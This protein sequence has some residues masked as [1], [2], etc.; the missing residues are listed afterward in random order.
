MASE[1]KKHRIY[2][3]IYSL[4]KLWS[5]QNILRCWAQSKWMLLKGRFLSRT[6]WVLLDPVENLPLHAMLEFSPPQHQM[7]DFEDGVFRIF[8]FGEVLDDAVF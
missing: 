2:L 7:E 5:K 1:N 8:L 3:R 4:H 6:Q